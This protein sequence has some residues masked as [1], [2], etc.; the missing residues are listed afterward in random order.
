MN[1]TLP[2]VTAITL[3]TCTL[4]GAVPGITTTS[5]PSAIERLAANEVQRYVYL[6]T[7]SL[8]AIS[9]Q[10]AHECIVVVRADR[11]QMIPQELQK[12]SHKLGKEDYLIR[13]LSGPNG[14]RWWIIG[15]SDIG[16]LY[17][18]YRFAEKLGVRFYLHGDVLPDER[19]KSIPAMRDAGKPVFSTRGIQPFHDFSEGPDWWSTDDYLSYIS[20][21]AKMRM[22]FI[23]FHC[24]PEGMA[25]PSVWI[26]LPD[27]VGAQGQVKFSYPSTWANSAH[28]GVWQN[29]AMKSSNFSAGA[30]LLFS[31][32]TIGAESQKGMFPLPSTPE[33]NNRLFNNTASMFRTA[34]DYARSLGVKSCMGTETPITIPSLVK[35]RMKGKGLDPADPKAVQEVYKGIFTRIAEAYPVDYY[36][37]W[38]PEGW[39]WGG[40]TEADTKATMRDIQCALD[41]LN[42]IGN[43]FTLATSGWVLGPMQDRL[44]LDKVLPKKSP[45]SSINRNVGHT[46]V[47]PCFAEIKD[48][49]KWAIPWMEND[50]VLTAPQPWVGRMLFDAADA[51]RMGC[52]GLLG[53]HWRTKVLSMNV[54]ALAKAG[55]NQDWNTKEYRAFRTVAE[56]KDG[57]INGQIVTYGDPIDATTEDDIYQS[58]RYNTGGYRLVVPN[59]SYTVRL[60]FSELA[61]SEVG[62]RAFGVKLQGQS[63][64]ERVDIY[65]K[66]GKDKALDFVC[67]NVGVNDKKIR[68]DFV[69]QIEFPCIN[70]IVIDGMTGDGHRYS[71]KVNCGGPKIRDWEADAS[72]VADPSERRALPVKDFYT[73]FARA[74]FGGRV[75]Q[76]VGAIFT[77]M[78]GFGMPAPVALCPGGLIPNPVPWGTEKLRYAF[79][80]Q[81]A[82]LRDGIK[83]PG[84]RE[85]Y[86]YWLNTFRY[87]RALGELGCRR[88]ELDS[89]AEQLKAEPDQAKR[90]VVAQSMKK[91][92]IN[93]SCL[94]E[95]LIGY[96][97]AAL[98]TP[99]EMGTIDNL[100]RHN[101][102][103][104]AFLSL[105]DKQ[106]ESA[107]GQPL[108]ADAGISKLYA[109]S[110]RI[111]VPTV[112][113]QAKSGDKIRLKVIVLDNAQPSSA[114]L[115]WR[116]LGKGVFRKL[117][118]QHVN[119]AVYTVQLPEMKMSCEY[120]ITA[121]SS[122]GK[123]KWP[124]T[125]P[126]INQT[127]VVW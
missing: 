48:R 98:D 116:P 19:L 74:N 60:M 115:F 124:A 39:T 40:N 1:C 121:Q 80:D 20:Q 55:W 86:D 104:M 75:A 63:V 15:G 7:G 126:G 106:I 91:A 78:D 88:A 81:L 28:P 96:Q 99:G 113:T 33:Q 123:L 110:P 97:L 64:I 2:L 102:G 30:S 47:D 109:G 49:P 90:T 37:L 117:E 8:P 26:G 12:A 111:I 73:D 9:Q 68:L 23:G 125:A 18:A 13:T 44:A 120:Y 114:A 32:E 4:A 84:D 11:S 94:W 62:R 46:P 103:G 59:G 53:I 38:T 77:K 83:S 41:A 35:E 107:L 14:K 79:I 6:R 105:Y 45:M 10:Q 82:A 56:P 22:N 24:Y 57:P 50:P 31:D 21:L 17:G 100:E 42:S 65:E 27:D 89:L 52:T 118:L 119:R 112:R 25:E 127:V 61:Y 70:G 5:Q 36:W 3:F 85:R 34:F 29:I 67:P 54:A 72:I 71:R 87:V 93:L 101:R 43:P 69:A 66:A 122:T 51:K 95:A 58:V 16:T 108:P 76:S 92:R